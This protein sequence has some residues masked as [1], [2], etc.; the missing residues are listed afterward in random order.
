MNWIM[1]HISYQVQWQSDFLLFLQSL[2]NDFLSWFF[3]IV[4]N[5]GEEV[6]CF[7][8][9]SVI[10]WCVSKRAGYI[11]GFSLISA[12]LVNMAV[13]QVF[14]VP[15]PIGHNGIEYVRTPVEVFPQGYS[16]PSG[17]ATAAGSLWSSVILALRKRWLVVLG[18]L[19]MILIPLSRL[20]FAAH[21]P[22]D[23]TAGL[24]L[25]ILTALVINR[26]SEASEKAKKYL[27]AVIVFV[28][29]AVG[30]FVNHPGYWK[31]IGILAGLTS[32]YFMEKE[33]IKL[34]MPKKVCG[35]ISRT[36]LGLAGASI[37]CPLLGVL[38]PDSAV[39]GAFRYC[40]LG[41]WITAGAPALFSKLKI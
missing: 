28:F 41:L 3:Y 12:D 7:A 15:R 22:I 37:L 34:D 38:L 18:V 24:V 5:S 36:F 32:G 27:A 33:S 8:V 2:R 17:H 23:V 25:G 29:A 39:S 1:Q 20:Y 4:T 26:I 9:C 16:F 40:C 31:A 19:M 21:T 6:F 10:F 30:I 13:K 35:Y 11:I 14:Q